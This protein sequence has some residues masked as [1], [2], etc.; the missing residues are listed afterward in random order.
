MST[1]IGSYCRISQDLENE[2]LGVARQ[3]KDTHRL[4][5]QRGWQIEA[6]YIDNGVSAYRAVHRPEFE[7][8]LSD[9]RDGHLDGLVVYDL[10]RLARQPRDLERLID[11]YDTKPS[12]VFATVQGDL[13]LATSDGRFIARLMVNVANKSSSDTS[14]RIK[15]K[16]LEHAENGRPQGYRVLPFGYADSMTLDPRESAIVRKMG[17]WFRSGYS[18]HE[19]VKRL[20]KEGDFTRAG[21]PWINTS[22]RQILKNPRHAGFRVIDGRRYIGKWEHVFTIDEWDDLERQRKKRSENVRGRPNNSRY[23]LTRLVRCGRCGEAM[24]GMTK[25]NEPGMPLRRTYQCRTRGCGMCVHA[26]VLEHLVRESLL[27][28]LDGPLIAEAIQSQQGNSGVGDLY[29]EANRLEDRKDQIARDYAEGLMDRA[30][31]TEARRHLIYRINELQLEIDRRRT[32]ELTVRIDVGQS[33][34]DAWDKHEDGWRREL[35]E[36]AVSGI[37]VSKHTKRPLYLV[38]DERYRFDPDRVQIEWKI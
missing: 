36:V 4:A 13:N 23:L 29:D 5:E 33:L 26:D 32:R 27:F 18:Y 21:K 14:R 15:R 8:L 34:R 3:Q 17:D 20:N 35:I 37:M 28:R 10:D 7:R 9:L 12:L 6:D 11:I 25:R 24:G 30:D 1:R 2:G 19:I 38:G 16:I 22:I 31:F